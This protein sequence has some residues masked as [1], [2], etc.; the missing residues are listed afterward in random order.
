MCVEKLTKEEKTTLLELICNEQI[1]HMVA[2]DKYNT[3][4]YLFLEKLK[5]KIRD[6]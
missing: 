2:K 1:K 6:M 5:L 3:D 4:E